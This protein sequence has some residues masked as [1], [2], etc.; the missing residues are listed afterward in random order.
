M[1]STFATAGDNQGTRDPNILKL[2][3]T[4]RVRP[5]DNLVAEWRQHGIRD[6]RDPEKFTSVVCPG[7]RSCPLDRKPVD[8]DKPENENQRFPV[9]RRFACNVWDYGSQ[10]VKVL[11]S[12]PQVFDAFKEAAQNGID[13]TGSDWVI[14]RDGKG[15]QTSYKVT[16]MDASAGPQVSPDML[17]DVAKYEAPDSPERIF[18]ALEKFGIEYDSL[19]VPT[20]TEEEALAYV[21]PF[22]Q[23]KGLTIDQLVKTDQQ[24]AEWLHGAK[25]EQGMLGD[26]V[27]VA[28][29][30]VLETRGIVPPLDD[31]L[32][33]L[34]DPSTA[35]MVSAESESASPTDS[36]SEPSSPSPPSVGAGEI[37]MVAPNGLPV[38]VPATNKDSLLAAGFTM[39]PEDEPEA[40]SPTMQVEIA[41]NLV[42]LPRAEA[43][44]LIESGTATEVG[45]DSAPS[46]PE[47]AAPEPF[48]MP[49]PMEM[50]EAIVGD[51]DPIPMAFNAAAALVNLGKAEFADER[52]ADEYARERSETNGEDAGDKQAVAEAAQAEHEAGATNEADENLLNCPHCDK[53]FKSKGGLSNHKKKEHPNGQAAARARAAQLPPPLAPPAEGSADQSLVEEVKNMVAASPI[54]KD[55]KKILDVFEEETGKKNIMEMTDPELNKLKARLEKEM[56]AA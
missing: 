7:P 51:G 54:A 44:A 20:Y 21:L 42:E 35:P 28:L 43:G 22:S 52:L 40:E 49:G 12:G 31:A 39:P 48:V 5:L 23:H 47:E 16:R 33:A 4:T 13:V 32:A 56:V 38:P 26:P 27:F 24:F 11:V 1:P 36:P 50:V 2:E 55:Y 37:L 53:K 46:E 34:P 14:N 17:L 41:G 8:P 9:S 30:K 29:Q 18:D 15:R 10:S 3:D 45:A 19:K 6:P 25:L